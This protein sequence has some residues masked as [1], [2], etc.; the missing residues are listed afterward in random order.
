MASK[1]QLCDLGSV[2][3]TFD[4]KIDDHGNRINLIGYM[5][6]RPSMELKVIGIE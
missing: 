2:H 1:T 5:R 4:E 6:R 3:R